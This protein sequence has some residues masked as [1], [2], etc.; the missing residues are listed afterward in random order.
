[1]AQ[2]LHN[3]IARAEQVED[4]PEELEAP[5]LLCE[6]PLGQ[7]DELGEE[8][9]NDDH[10]QHLAREGP[11]GFFDPR[12]DALRKAPPGSMISAEISKARNEYKSKYE[13]VASQKYNEIIQRVNVHIDSEEYK[14]AIKIIDYFFPKVYRK[15]RIW[16]TSLEPL[17]NRCVEKTKKS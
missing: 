1:M 6:L 15:S 3:V 2:P 10:L 7:Q 9:Q 5:H 8:A 4:A 16:K 12:G 11:E 13:G 14:P 17:Y